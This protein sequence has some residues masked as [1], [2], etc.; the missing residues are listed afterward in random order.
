MPRDVR[1]SLFDARQAVLGILEFTNGKTIQDYKSDLM[2]RCATERQF[3]IVGEALARIRAVDPAM[4]DHVTE[5]HRIIGFRNVLIHG[6][7][8][9]DHDAVWRIVT[10]E[11][12]TLRQELEELLK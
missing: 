7:D 8:A 11:L 12:P 2:L 6:Y 3:E 10:E 1:A 4:L 9:I 5:F